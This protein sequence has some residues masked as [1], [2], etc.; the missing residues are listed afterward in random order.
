M[1]R[2]SVGIQIFQQPCWPQESPFLP[3]PRY[4]RLDP[5]ELHKLCTAPMDP[6]STAHFKPSTTWT[7][8]KRYL[9]W[10]CQGYTA[11][12]LLLLT[13][14]TFKIKQT[15]WWEW[16]QGQHWTE[17]QHQGAA[18][19]SAAPTHWPGEE[20]PLSTTENSPQFSKPNTIK[21][22]FA[23]ENRQERLKLKMVCDGLSLPRLVPAVP[24]K[25]RECWRPRP[26][27]LQ[28]GYDD[29][30]ISCRNAIWNIYSAWDGAMK[31]LT[32]APQHIQKLNCCFSRKY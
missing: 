24:A 1:L 14:V 10:R 3:V 20:D 7:P 29:S 31:S 17:E 18:P 28:G 30:G 15:C 11:W 19:P 4:Q 6:F 8:I 26:C 12:E 27:P 2:L 23:P 16:Q 21:M 22:I 13:F 5:E 25:S 9:K 32:L